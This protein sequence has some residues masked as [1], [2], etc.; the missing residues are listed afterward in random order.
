MVLGNHW[1]D[2]CRQYEYGK[3]V[4]V[5]PHEQTSTF[6]THNGRRGMRGDGHVFPKAYWQHS[7][8]LSKSEGITRLLRRKFSEYAKSSEQ[9]STCSKLH[10]LH[11]T[12][13]VE[14]E[15]VDVAQWYTKNMS[16]KR[17]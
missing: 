5:I 8:S 14:S 16:G 11:T 12:Y 7:S 13:E 17:R 6:P 1:A 4:H 3:E 10:K 15:E 2:L 9:K